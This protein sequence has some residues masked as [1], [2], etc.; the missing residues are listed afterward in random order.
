MCLVIQ[1]CGCFTTIN[2]KINPL[3]QP[4]SLHPKKKL[5]LLSIAFVW[6]LTIAVAIGPLLDN[7]NVEPYNLIV[8]QDV[9]FNNRRIID[10][11]ALKAFV[12][13]L[14]TFQPGLHNST[15]NEISQVV[16]SRSWRFLT[17]LIQSK[18]SDKF[19]VEAF[20]G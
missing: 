2:L 18:Y 3:F 1:T 14:F 16:N 11:N 4:Y 19:K 6:L 20:H 12:L 5:L 10:T 8:S 15:E 9:Y 13:K 17:H 7:G